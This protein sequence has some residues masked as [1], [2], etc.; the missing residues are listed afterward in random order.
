VL[1]LSGKW[2]AAGAFIGYREALVS[3]AEAPR[4]VIKACGKVVECGII[5]V[6]YDRDRDVA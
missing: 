5:K 1:F 2:S 4:Q 6:S 3:V